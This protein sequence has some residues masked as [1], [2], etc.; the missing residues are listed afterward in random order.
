MG[1]DC[2]VC[3][4]Q[5][6]DTARITGEA[7]KED[8]TV[9]RAALPAI[10]NPEDLNALEAALHVRDRHGGTVTAM[11]MGPLNA[12]EVLR[13]CLFRGADRTI[14]IN[15][16]RAAASDTLATSYILSRAIRTLPRYDLVFCGRQAIDG[17]TAQVGPQLAEKLG[18]AQ[19]T[20]FER[21][22][23]LDGRTARVRRN[24]G[25]G[26]EVVEARLPL[27]LTVL[28]SANTPRPPSARRVM[29]YK[30]ARTEPEV[31]KEVAEAMP[32]ASEQKREEEWARRLEALKMNGLVMDQWDLDH[33]E[34]DLQW[35]GWAGSPTKVHRVQ[36][37]VLTKEGYT[38]IPPTEEGV[39][40]LIHELIVDRTLG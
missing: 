38:E 31:G 4:K 1:Y 10:F 6:P 39:H 28:G 2:V 18:I 20:Y 34:A 22:V 3:I 36:S 17:D 16:R 23:E 9:N 40:Q 26:W 27:L 12:C 15:D 24:V 5:V 21:F 8:G 14:I 19:V 29:R 30:R 37:I 33:V 7:M 35:C 25:N 11:T 32:K 13:D